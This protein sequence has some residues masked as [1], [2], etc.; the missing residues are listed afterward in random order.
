MTR[1][2]GETGGGREAVC[3]SDSLEASHLVAPALS[4]CAPWPGSHVK[5]LS[6]SG[7]DHLTVSAAMSYSDTANQFDHI[8]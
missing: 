7:T 2:E 5:V 6:H 4:V 1:G 3:V 8:L